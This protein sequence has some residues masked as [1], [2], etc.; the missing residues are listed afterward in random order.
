MNRNTRQIHDGHIFAKRTMRHSG[1]SLYSQYEDVL[2]GSFTHIQVC[3]QTLPRLASAEV[4]KIR[5]KE[6]L[7]VLPCTA[8]QV[9]TLSSGTVITRE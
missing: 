5:A 7:S 4:A 1:H 2:H 3:L 9:E 8:I 6:V